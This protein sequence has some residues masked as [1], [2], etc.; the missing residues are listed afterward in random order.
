[1]L[2]GFRDR[3]LAHQIDLMHPVS[4]RADIVDH[5]TESIGRLVDGAQQDLAIPCRLRQSGAHLLNRGGGLVYVR[6]Q[7]FGVLGE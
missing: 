7:R 1:V 6:G 5:R 2:P 3:L 4:D